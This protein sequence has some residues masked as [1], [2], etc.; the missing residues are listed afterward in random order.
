MY[1]RRA[2]NLARFIPAIALHD[3]DIFGLGD[4][5]E[6]EFVAE[7]MYEDYVRCA[8]ENAHSGSKS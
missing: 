3:Q 4:A 5:D 6:A 1:P 7:C 8:Q 2:V